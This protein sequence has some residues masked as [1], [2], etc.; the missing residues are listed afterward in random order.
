[1]AYLVR[2]KDSDRL[3]SVEREMW[4][5]FR[6]AKLLAHGLVGPGIDRLVDGTPAPQQI[7]NALVE[8]LTEEGVEGG[9]I[10][11]DDVGLAY[12]PEAAAEN[13]MRFGP[14]Q[15]EARYANILEAAT[16]PVALHT[17]VV[18]EPEPIA[19]LTVLE[20]EPGVSDV[21]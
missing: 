17:D 16:A 8:P 18:V 9:L 3:E 12:L 4:A 20:G 19:P 13:I 5:R 11:L 6:Q 7:T 15:L 10:V 21:G 1:M 2:F 14:E